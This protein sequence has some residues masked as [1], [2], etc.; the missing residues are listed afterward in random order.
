MN[1]Y[2][3]LP[4]WVYVGSSSGFSPSS[5]SNSGDF[6]TTFVDITKCIYDSGLTGNNLQSVSSVRDSGVGSSATGENDY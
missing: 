5:T 4:F 6:E 1:Y 3:K 2:N